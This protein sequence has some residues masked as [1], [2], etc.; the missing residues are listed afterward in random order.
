VADADR[1]GGI[2]VK[3]EKIDVKKFIVSRRELVVFEC[4][5]TECDKV[6]EAVMRDSGYRALRIEFCGYD[7]S[8]NPLVSV[9]V[10]FAIAMS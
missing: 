9:E 7:D 5:L 8:R 6:V 4:L 2:M 1:G 3:E 10:E